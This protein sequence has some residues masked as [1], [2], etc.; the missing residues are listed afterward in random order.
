M[1]EWEGSRAGGRYTMLEW[2][3]SRAGGRYRMLERG[4]GV[5]WMEWTILMGGRR[6]ERA[7]YRKGR[8]RKRVVSRE[9]K[10]KM[11]G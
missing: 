6:R 8:C 7:G 11:L 9:G 2:E 5:A 1:L 10:W 3:G 4:G